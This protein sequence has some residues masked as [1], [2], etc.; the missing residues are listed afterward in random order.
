MCAD[1]IGHTSLNTCWPRWRKISSCGSRSTPGRASL[2][3]RKPK[4]LRMLFENWVASLVPS[5]S[6][7]SSATASSARSITTAVQA[8]PKMKWKS[9]SS[10]LLWPDV[11]SGFTT[12]T[13]FAVPLRS[14]STAACIENVAELHATFMS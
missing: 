4:S 7:V 6:H 10:K 8:S 11:I 2:E 14:A 3:F 13:Q 12:T 5:T 1:T 9:R